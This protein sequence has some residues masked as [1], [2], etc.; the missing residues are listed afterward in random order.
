MS[1]HPATKA[2]AGGAGGVVDTVK[3]TAGLGEF[4]ESVHCD[5][6]HLAPAGPCYLDEDRPKDSIDHLVE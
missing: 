2:F 6:D 4:E 1:G 5:L 3:C